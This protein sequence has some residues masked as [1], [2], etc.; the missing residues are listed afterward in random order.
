MPVFSAASASLEQSGDVT[1][2]KF[3]VTAGVVTS[4]QR[5]NLHDRVRAAAMMRADALMVAVPARAA[6]VVVVAV[7]ALIGPE[8]APG[9]DAGD[10]VVLITLDGARTEEIFGGLDLDILKS[11]LRENQKVEETPVVQALL[12]DDAE[13]RRAKLM[14][15]FW[16]LVTEHGSIA[17]DPA[18]GSARAASQ[19]ALVLVSRLRRDPA[20]RAASTTSSRAT[21]RFAT[22]IRPC[23]RRSANAHG[24]AAREGCHVRAAGASSTRSSSTPK[25]PR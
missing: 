13:E 6:V 10:N 23:S 2:A 12:G 21:I 24:A 17:G 25:A 14:P 3:D 1:A 18:L 22:R 8:C 9:R 7:L 5:Q 15:F 19:P 20:R 4:P 11:T 16:S